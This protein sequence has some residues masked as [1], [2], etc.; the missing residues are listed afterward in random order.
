MAR[1][2]RSRQNLAKTNSACLR[3][4]TGR[5]IVDDLSGAEEPLRRA[6]P[7]QSFRLELG[8]S[9]HS[10]NLRARILQLRIRRQ[11]PTTKEPRQSEVLSIVGLRPAQAIS[12]P[13]SLVGQALRASGADIRQRKTPNRG[14][15]ELARDLL[16]PAQLMKHRGRLGPHQVGGNELLLRQWVESGLGQTRCYNNCGVDDEHSATGTRSA[17]GGDNIGHR[18]M[19]SGSTPARRYGEDRLLLGDFCQI[20]FIDHVLSADLGGSQPAGPDPAT[21]GFRVAFRAARCLRDR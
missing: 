10:D 7:G 19:S 16:L 13:P 18:S 20:G 12:N 15:R 4:R 11:Q 9:N 14:S 2:M 8:W 21:H 6:S 1:G 5:R 3:T 17:D